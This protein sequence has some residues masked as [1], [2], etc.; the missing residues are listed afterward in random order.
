VIAG[1]PLA[2]LLVQLSKR[3]RDVPTTII[4]QFI[5]AFG[6]WILADRLGLS[7]VLTVVSYAFW[8]A[9]WSPAVT[10]ARIRL[11]AYAVWDTAVFVLN[12]LAFLF[13][14][15]Q[16][17]PILMSLDPEVRK[18]YLFVAGMVVL[19]V[20][21]VRIV[22]VMIHNTVDRWRIRRFGFHPRR[23]AVPPTVR[24]ALIVSWSGMRGVITLAAALALPDASEG[25]FPFRDLI[26]LTAFAVVIGTLV[27]Q[28]MT[29]RPLIRLLDVHD[30]DPVGREVDMARDRALEA[31]L[32]TF[33][34]DTSPAAESV[35]QEFA[36]HLK[37]ASADEASSDDPGATHSVIHRKALDAARQVVF[38]MRAR[39]DI[40]D[41]AFHR[42]EEE[43][44]WLEMG[45]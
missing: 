44:D 12:V 18:R 37:G 45:A 14:G 40:G 16:V 11:P 17:R 3:V 43:F 34:G 42:L 22:W 38:D 15:L 19:T 41:D 23:P 7:S 21:V 35:R 27:L 28:G 13:I 26:V 30:D 9:R 32:A 8:V 39:E 6:V 33:E 31:A 36:S 10:P 29:L 2:W 24:G 4:L 20:I 25:G 5:S 1:F